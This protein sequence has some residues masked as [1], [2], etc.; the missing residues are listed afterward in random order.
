MDPASGLPTLPRYWF[1]RVEDA[2][3]LQVRKDHY[4]E[5][6]FI[7]TYQHYEDIKPG[8]DDRH[9]SR[10]TSICR[11]RVYRISINA[12]VQ[13]G[14]YEELISARFT[15]FDESESE[16]ALPLEKITPEKVRTYAAMLMA[17]LAAKQAK[18]KADKEQR[19]TILGDFPPKRLPD[20]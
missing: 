17:G 13:I 8:W 7:N 15:S 3:C 9:S 20:E 16:Y 11:A 10:R 4:F 2:E 5:G 14:R 19:G 12:M 6:K 18:E 1:W